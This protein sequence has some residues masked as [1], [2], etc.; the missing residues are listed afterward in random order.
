LYRVGN[1]PSENDRFT[2]LA[3]TGANTSEHDF[4]SENGRTS[5][6]DD[7][8]G[9]TDNS[10]VTT[11]TETMLNALQ[12]KARD[13]GKELNLINVIFKL[14]LVKEIILNNPFKSKY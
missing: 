12:V 5:S 11:S 2:N 3:E 8:N 10:R 14:L 6:G 4:S 1:R 13:Y 7:F 9:I